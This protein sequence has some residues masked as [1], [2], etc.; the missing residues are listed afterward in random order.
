MH[1][2]TNKQTS[3]R[4]KRKA[5]LGPAGAAQRA[6]AGIKLYVFSSVARCAHTVDYVITS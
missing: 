2:Q 4:L 5:I 6:P 3:R 1:K